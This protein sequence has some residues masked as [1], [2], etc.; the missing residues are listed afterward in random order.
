VKTRT[1]LL[2]ALAL[3]SALLIGRAPTATTPSVSADVADV[4]PCTADGDLTVGS[5][6]AGVACLQYFLL[7]AGLYT[8]PVNSQF[9]AATSDAVARFQLANPP[10]RVDGLGNEPTLVAMGLFSGFGAL[11]QSDCLADSDVVI[12]T[13]GDSAECV[14]SRLTNLGYYAGPIDG[15][16]GRSSSDALRTYQLATPGLNAD[17]IGDTRTLAALDIWSGLSSDRRQAPVG[18]TPAVAG[19]PWPAPR[20][21][22]PEY[23]VNAAGIPHFGNRGIC[24]LADANTIAAEFANDGANDETQ[25]WAVYVASREG[26]CNYLTINDNPATRDYSHCTF[27]LNALSGM[28]N[29]D[30]VLG[31]RGWTIDNVKESM[32]NCADAASDL[33]VYCG[34]GPWTP[35]YSC[36]R[37]WAGDLGPDGDA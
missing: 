32:R 22:L 4:A 34:R 36:V 3:A 7:L 11:P 26:G 19:G 1:W 14:Q 20:L 9:D 29:A 31:R 12:G 37:P 30:A 35:P 28:F 6:G 10:L 16:F 21:F 18:A 2:G 33:W 15:I 17:G 27:Q 24:S 13:Q 25:Q 5:Q 8:G 23:R